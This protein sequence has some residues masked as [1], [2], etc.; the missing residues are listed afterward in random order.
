MPK[1]AAIRSHIAISA[2]Y[3]L[4]TLHVEEICRLV[5]IDHYVYNK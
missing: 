2:T 5:V 3:L 1:D 4:S